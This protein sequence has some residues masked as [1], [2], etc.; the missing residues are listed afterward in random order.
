[1]EERI[2][3]LDRT[4]TV[5]RLVPHHTDLSAAIQIRLGATKATGNSQPA[6]RVNFLAGYDVM[7]LKVANSSPHYSFSLQ[8]YYRREA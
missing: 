3:R 6:Q 1:M 5:N 8:S 7:V 2:D 4:F